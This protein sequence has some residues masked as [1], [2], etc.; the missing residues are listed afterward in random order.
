MKEDM[1]ADEVNIPLE[2]LVSRPPDCGES[3]PHFRRGFHHGVIS[4]L[5]AIE[6]G[7]SIEELGQWAETEVGAWRDRYQTPEW[8]PKLPYPSK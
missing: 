7:A 2:T 4:V 8:P 3:E 1:S 6:A 5:D